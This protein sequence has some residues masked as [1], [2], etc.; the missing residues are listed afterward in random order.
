MTA[1][2]SSVE[3]VGGLAPLILKAMGV[4]SIKGFAILP[5]KEEMDYDFLWE[6]Y[7]M[8]NE[9]RLCTRRAMVDNV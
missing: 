3:E 6:L 5:L 4:W 8:E 1:V 9:M 2:L 7:S